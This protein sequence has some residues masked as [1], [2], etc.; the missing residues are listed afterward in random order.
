MSVTGNES[1]GSEEEEEQV[2]NVSIAEDEGIEKEQ[3]QTL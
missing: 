1:L 2:G 3:N